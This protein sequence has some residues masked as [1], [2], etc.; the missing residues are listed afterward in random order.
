MLLIILVVLLL[1]ILL[2]QQ[3]TVVY[4]TESYS[5][6]ALMSQYTELPNNS[7]PFWFYEKTMY[8]PA[9]YNPN[10]RFPHVL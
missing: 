6:P 4:A 9:Y 1:I 10:Y 7:D 2:S 8:Y 5:D 3:R